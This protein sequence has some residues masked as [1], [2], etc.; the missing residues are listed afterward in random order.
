MIR[1][2]N[3]VFY[4]ETENTEYIFRITEGGY[5]EHL[6]Y[7]AKLNDD[8]TVP[9]EDKLFFVRGSCIEVDDVSR[10]ISMEHFKSEF[11]ENGKGDVRE[12]SVDIVHADGTRTCDFVFMSSDITE[13]KYELEGLPSSYAGNDSVMSLVVKM[14]DNNSGSIL[15]LI[16]GVFEK[17]NVITRA[18]RIINNENGS[19]RLRKIMSSQLDLDEYKQYD[20][21]GFAGAW[22]YEM[23]M[24]RRPIK[25]GI[26]SQ[27][28]FCLN[29][30][31]RFN[32][33]C[34]VCESKACEDYGEV[35]G[36]NLVYSGNHYESAYM[37]VFGKVRFMQ[38]INPS[39]FGFVLER[40]G[41]FVTPEAVMTYS[42][43]GFRDM[44]RNMH[45][46]VRE[47]IVRGEWKYKERPVLINSW[48]SCYFD[49]D[50]DKLFTLAKTASECGMELLVIDDGWFAGRNDDT[51]SLGDWSVDADKFP[52]GLA[53][54]SDRLK[55]I[56]MDLGIWV[57]PEMISENSDLYRAHPEWA[58]RIPGKKHALGRNQMLLDLTDNDVRQYIT[59]AMCRVFSCA[60]IKYVK[61]D[62]NR[63]VSD[64]YG[65]GSTD[66][67]LEF[68]HRYVLGLYEILGTLTSEFPHI[69]FESCSGGGNRF[70]LGMLCYTPQIW[71]SDNTD[72]SCRVHI[73]TG[74]SYG[75][76]MSCV[77]A[78]VS[79]CPNHQTR[80][81]VP[82]STR[83][84]VAVFGALGYECN[85][86]ELSQ[87]ELG[88]IREQIRFYKKYRKNIQ[89]G[90][91]YR[92]M[93]DENEIQWMSYDDAA[94]TGAAM[95][96]RKR[97]VP[98]ASFS[99]IKLCGL[100]PDAVYEFTGGEHEKIMTTGDVFMKAGVKIIE[101]FVHG[102]NENDARFLVDDSTRIYIL[103][104]RK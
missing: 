65:N 4:L 15:E 50:E 54:L 22:A 38:G 57:E 32:P 87:L 51:S 43:S 80:R 46:F 55:S 3:N 98:G 93:E 99:R 5:A 88:Q 1:E 17:A 23:N 41:V 25:A 11:S 81:V 96:Y 90:D 100:K 39:E 85:L 66:N 20:F 82:L 72:A 104:E 19:I 67:Q 7:G 83:F 36:F 64:S 103:E 78:H 2:K 92:L 16:Y 68:A 8:N 18:A 73:Q 53:N 40:G 101:G 31:S 35:Y 58:V 9:F 44:S 76:P 69:L 91:F 61:W 12:I 48:E 6:Y 102:D 63:I 13:G 94:G 26:T 24:V 29:S 84:D 60:D 37:D 10:R 95:I 27:A 89:S 47:N 21:V 59:D 77:G 30:S 79:Q 70:D 34:M 86:D 49:I 71:G 14:K 33:F 42:G 75:Y 28:S 45:R 56:G 62:M 52:S 74:Y 97:V